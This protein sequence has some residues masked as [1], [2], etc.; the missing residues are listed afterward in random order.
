MTRPST[1]AALVEAGLLQRKPP[2]VR[3]VAGW[4]ARSRKDLADK[5]RFEISVIEA[6]LPKQLSA[7]E[8]DNWASAV[9]TVYVAADKLYALLT[10]NQ[11][12]RNWVVADYFSPFTLHQRLLSS[13]FPQIS[14]AEEEGRAGEPEITALSAERDRVSAVLDA[15]RADNGLLAE[16]LAQAHPV[17]A[18]DTESVVA[19]R[20]P[21][22]A[23][24]LH[25][26]ALPVFAL[27]AVLS[28]PTISARE[29][30]SSFESSGESRH[31]QPKRIV[32]Q[33]SPSRHGS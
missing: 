23:P 24:W 25:T 22:L 26:Y 14:K 19:G 20:W 13:W 4:L 12:L 31:R 9:N 2:D 21:L 10:Q 6:Y 17:E 18:R 11:P 29:R 32:C 5:E 8:V 3:R 16:C 1:L 33:P 28:P 30:R 27:L 15:V 7:Q